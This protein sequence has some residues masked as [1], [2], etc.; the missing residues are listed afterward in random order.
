M[1]IQGK[2]TYLTGVSTG[3]ARRSKIFAPAIGYAKDGHP[4]AQVI[5]AEWY[6]PS[7]SSDLTSDGKY[8]NALDGFLQVF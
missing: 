8:P 6:I 2:M 3:N 4:V 1:A 5:A 7:N